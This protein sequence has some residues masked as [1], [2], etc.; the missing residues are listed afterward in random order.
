MGVSAY[1]Q[2]SK[3]STSDTH[4]TEGWVGRKAGQEA[5]EERQSRA[6]AGNRTTIYRT[7]SS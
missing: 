5:L 1:L 3:E 2:A 7:S 6:S 4:W